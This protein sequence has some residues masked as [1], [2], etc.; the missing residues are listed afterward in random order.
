MKYLIKQP[1]A[2]A[3]ST[4]ELQRNCRKDL[5]RQTSL[6]VRGEVNLTFKLHKIEFITFALAFTFE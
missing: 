2:K 1:E 3:Y 4:I 5:H 6:S